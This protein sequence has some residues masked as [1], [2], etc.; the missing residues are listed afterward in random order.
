MPL[1]NSH[2]LEDKYDS[3][4]IMKKGESESFRK[5]NLKG[6]GWLSQNEVSQANLRHRGG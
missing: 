3:Q 4:G 6:S 2:Q 5:K 1:P